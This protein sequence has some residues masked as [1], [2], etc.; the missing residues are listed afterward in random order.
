VVVRSYA[1]GSV[2]L[3]L[4]LIEYQ[5]N[6][7]IYGAN[8]KAGLS[9][10]RDHPFRAVLKHQTTDPRSLLMWALA[11]QAQPRVSPSVHALTG[12]FLAVNVTLGLE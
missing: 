9:T 3:R 5:Y 2:F 8:L 12:F 4:L 6:L 7:P 1:D 11:P 10:Q